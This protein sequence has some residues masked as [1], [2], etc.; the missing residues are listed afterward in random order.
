M[1][2][3]WRFKK[4]EIKV[5]T[6]LSIRQREV[7]ITYLAASLETNVTSINIANNITNL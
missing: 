3:N 7:Q 5:A 2:Y 1:A 4:L 6:V